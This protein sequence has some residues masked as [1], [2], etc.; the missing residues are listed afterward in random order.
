MME[1]FHRSMN[2]VRKSSIPMGQDRK[3]QGPVGGRQ[4]VKMGAG[5]PYFRYCPWLRDSRA[6]RQATLAAQGA[7]GPT[8]SWEHCPGSINLTHIGKKQAIRQGMGLLCSVYPP[9]SW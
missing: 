8:T 6:P 3:K 5:S 2:Q 4:S 9:K 7:L 1:L